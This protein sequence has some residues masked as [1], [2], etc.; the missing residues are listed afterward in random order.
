MVGF[1][2]FLCLGSVCVLGQVCS[3]DNCGFLGNCGWFLSDV[4]PPSDSRCVFLWALE[5]GM[6]ISGCVLHVV[7]CARSG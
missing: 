1:V 5:L 7:V 3:G 6:C 4:L 2:Y